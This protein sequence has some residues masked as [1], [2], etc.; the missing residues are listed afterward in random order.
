MKKRTKKKLAKFGKKTAKA[1]ITAP[2][3][4]LWWLTKKS[5]SGGKSVIVKTKTKV[6]EKKVAKKK[7][8]TQAKYD[9]LKE[10]RLKKGKLPHFENKLYNNKSTIGLILGARGTG[11]SAIGMRLLENFK[12]KTDKQIYALGFKD[13]SLPDWIKAIGNIEEI[14]NNS[15][16]LIDEGGVEFSS[17]KAMSGAN[18]FLSE[19]LLIARHKDL[20]VIFI[21]QNSSNLEINAIRQADYLVMKPSS[22]LQKDFER[23]KIKDVYSQVDKDFEELNDPGLTYIYANNYLGFVSNSLPSFWSDKVSKGYSKR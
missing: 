11:K 6:E 12:A 22:L 14:K 9:S 23:K 4:G 1:V 10:L 20:S 13:E 17:R 19:L 8:K 18:T 21:T 15:V 5:Y 3:K 2:F 7:P 16:I